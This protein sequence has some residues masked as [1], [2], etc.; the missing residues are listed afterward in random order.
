MTIKH[1]GLD[2][3]WL[4]YATVRIE[5]PDGFVVYFDPGRYGVLDDYYARDGDL[6]LV[7]HN[8][9][10]DSDAIEQVAAADATVV[11]F[12]GVDAATIDRDVVPV[13]DLP[14]ETVRV[15]EEAHLTVG[16]VDVWSLPAFND[17]DGPHLRDGDVVHP[18]G[19]GCGFHI[20]IADRTVFWPGD[21]DVLEG[22]K[23]LEVSLFLANIGGSVVMDRREAADLAET[24]DPDLVLPIHYDTIPLLETDPDA[25]VVDVANRGIP[26]VLDDPDQV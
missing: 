4:G 1:D 7:T 10:Y 13:E 12:E 15:D 18:Q 21:S 6:I 5:S 16:E 23:H 11:A 26:V 3:S 14:Y 20:S 24:L 25:F 17:P 9:H 22:H 8:H 2:V 19:F